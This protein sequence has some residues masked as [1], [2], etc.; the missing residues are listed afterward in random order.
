MLRCLICDD[1]PMVLDALG[2]MIERRWPDVVVDRATGFADAETLLDPAHAVALVDLTMPDAAPLAGIKRLRA[3][4][5]QVPIVVFSGTMDDAMLLELVALHV[6]GL[7][8]KVEAPTV[9]LAAIELELAGGRYFPP[10]LAEIA[11]RKPD[12]VPAAPMR[13]TP[14][15]KEVLQF[16][17]A[18][19][20]NKE[21]AIALGLSPATVKTHV[22]Q[23]IA[24][25]GAANRAEATARAINL[26]LI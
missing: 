15:Q 17:A 14:R 16:L 8:S 10:R 9:V 7:V 12:L 13:I 18:G 2:Q 4:A 25:I 22:S 5:P 3:K 24:V 19:R 21:I 20:S 23:I 1:H 11:L 6:Q 26:G